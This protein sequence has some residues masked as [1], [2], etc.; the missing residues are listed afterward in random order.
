MNEARKRLGK[1]K[2]DSPEGGT[3]VISGSADQGG[4][5]IPITDTPAV[6]SRVR[7]GPVLHIGQLTGIRAL[8]ALWVLTFHF[9]PELL[10][11]FGFLYP[12]VPLFNVGYLGV[13]LFFILSGFILTYTHLDRLVDQWGPRKMIGFLWLRLSRIWPVMFFMLLVWGAYM[14]YSLLVNNDGRLQFALDPA[15]FLAHVFL[16]QGW[17][18]A[19]HD[20]NPVDWSLSAEWLAYLTFAVLAVALAKMLTHLSSRALVIVAFVLILPMVFIGVGFQDGSDLLWDGD[21]IVA[22][23]VPLRVLTEFFGGATVALLV[24]RHGAGA[25]LPWFLKP[26]VILP[27]IVVVL[28]AV[29]RVDPA[30]RPRFATDWRINGHLMWGSSETVI[31]VPLFLLLIGSLAVSKRDLAT[32]FLASRLLVW[33]GKIS[34]AL[35]MV[36]W[37]FLDL[38]RRVISSKLHIP[39][40][41]AGW[42]SLSYR[43]AELIA[44]GLAVLAAHLLYR[45]LEEPCRR[46]MRAL[47]PKSMRV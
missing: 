26:S 32:R 16:V 4:L 33:G 18:T 24:I 28:Y 10:K 3:A 22:G 17:S 1:E 14:A 27:A 23:I 45:Y 41:L 46:T 7:P 36:H 21:H 31:V 47:L 29:Q 5:E 13:D 12:L 11:A 35:Y 9:R 42:S 34:F 15:R 8:A 2:M 30:L 40:D 44:I 20:W 38:L 43:G 25:E 37:L 19:H 6:A 39:D